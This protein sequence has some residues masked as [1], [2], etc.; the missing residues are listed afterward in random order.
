MMVRIVPHKIYTHFKLSDLP[1]S[2]LLPEVTEEDIKQEV[3]ESLPSLEASTRKIAVSC[4]PHMG[5][6]L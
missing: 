1:H 2:A 3:A 6:I 4:H 5:I